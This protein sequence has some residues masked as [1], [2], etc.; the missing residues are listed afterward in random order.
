MSYEEKGAW[1]YLT[2]VIGAYGGYLAVLIDRLGSTPVSE[3]PFVG[4]LLWSLGISIGLSIVGRIAV[5]IAKPS[6]SYRV[7]ARDREIN[8]LGER[9]GGGVLA[10]AMIVPF[11]LSLADADNFWVAN[12]IYAAFVLSALVSTPVKLIA[13]RQ[14]M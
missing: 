1:V 11:G 14:G 12:A 3:V 6:D 4:T 2:V 13:Y 9:V 10:A 8:R 7:D 5:E